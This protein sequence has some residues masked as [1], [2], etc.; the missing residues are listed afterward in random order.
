MELKSKCLIII[1][2]C[3]IFMF[4]YY[5]AKELMTLIYAQKVIY[6]SGFKSQSENIYCL[7]VCLFVYLF[8]YL[9]IYL[10]VWT[11]ILFI[12][13]ETVNYFSV[14][15]SIRI[16]NKNTVF[17]LCSCKELYFSP[18][19]TELLITVVWRFREKHYCYFNFLV[20]QQMLRNISA[21]FESDSG[22]SAW[23]T[24]YMGRW[25]WTLHF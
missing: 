24:T 2:M 21:S 1:F 25:K 22:F 16:S 3:F 5:F 12:Q 20:R 8:I 23:S 9:F 13:F 10:C 19:F 15:S 11:F 7:F 6:C 17:M 18:F 4:L 14:A